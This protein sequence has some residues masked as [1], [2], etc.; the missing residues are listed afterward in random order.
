MSK[1]NIFYTFNER[2]LEGANSISGTRQILDFRTAIVLQGPISMRHNF[3]Y[4]VVRFYL[5]NYDNLEVILSTWADQETSIFDEF[6]SSGRFHLVKTE[7]P[8]FR[9]ISNINLQIVSSRVGLD[10]AKSLGVARVV[11]SRTDQAVLDQFALKSIEKYSQL[12]GTEVTSRI[13]VLDRNSFLYR[14][15]GISDM[16]QY[17]DL[18]T[19]LLFW[20][21]G[22]D[23]RRIEDVFDPKPR[24]ILE[25]ASRNT[26]ETYLVTSYL[27]L[28][29]ESIDFTF[30]RHVENLRKYFMV[31][32]SFQLGYVWNK[33][34]N[35][36]RPWKKPGSLPEFREIQFIDW[37]NLKSTI[38]E[39]K[40][41]FESLNNENG[42]K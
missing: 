9:G 39:H 3:T 7:Y 21:V 13:V 24:N 22:L 15:Y 14:L 23:S 5:S 10:V 8:H 17:S 32:D 25:Y 27:S 35:D 28:Q 4:K 19:L 31:L 12:F 38:V 29:G 30:E 20:S 42:L 37:L 6:V 33:Y 26:G 1:S 16:F 18:E 36:E 40:T 41:E 11:K 2:F 34:T